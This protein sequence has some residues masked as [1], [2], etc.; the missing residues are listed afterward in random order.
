MVNTSKYLAFVWIEGAWL[1]YTGYIEDVVEFSSSM[2]TA[3]SNPPSETTITL[4]SGAVWRGGHTGRCWCASLRVTEQGFDLQ[5]TRRRSVK[6]A[7]WCSRWGQQS[8]GG[9]R[10]GLWWMMLKRFQVLTWASGLHCKLSGEMPHEGTSIHPINT[11]AK[12]YL[13]TIAFVIAHEYV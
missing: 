7:C 1:H 12:G 4:F 10:A 11:A 8:G 5:V 2:L 6:S 3:S 13:W 9:G